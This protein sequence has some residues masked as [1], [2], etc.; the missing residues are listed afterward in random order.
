MGGGDPCFRQTLCG[1][2]LGA[3]RDDHCVMFSEA[4]ERAAASSAPPSGFGGPP[5]VAWIEEGDWGG[6]PVVDEYGHDW[7]KPALR[8]RMVGDYLEVCVHCGLERVGPRTKESCAGAPPTAPHEPR[9][10]A[11]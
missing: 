4:I 5:F 9:H 10:R 3:G 8:Q 2:R 1:R 7:Q 6:R 11:D